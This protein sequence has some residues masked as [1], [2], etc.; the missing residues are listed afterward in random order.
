[1]KGQTRLETPRQVPQVGVLPPLS[2]SAPCGASLGQPGPAGAQRGLCHLPG[3]ASRRRGVAALSGVDPRPRPAAG[4]SRRSTGTVPSAGEMIHAGLKL[5]HSEQQQHSTQL[6]QI[7]GKKKLTRLEFLKKSLYTSRTGESFARLSRRD[8][9][10]WACSGRRQS[11]APKS[12][13]RGGSGKGSARVEG[14]AAGCGHRTRP[15][16]RQLGNQLRCKAG[17]E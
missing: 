14:A 7:I 11:A 4:S 1:M 12:G 8:L 13:R 10:N 6:S 3:P 5:T 15:A 2:S 17:E 16:T 9:R